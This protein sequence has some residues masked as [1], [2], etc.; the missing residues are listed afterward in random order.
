VLAGV[1]MTVAVLLEGLQ[2]LAPDRSSNI[3]AAFYAG[4]GGST[5]CE[6]HLNGSRLR[7]DPISVLV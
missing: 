6:G 3:P 1:L 4:G 5:H 7:I 2:A